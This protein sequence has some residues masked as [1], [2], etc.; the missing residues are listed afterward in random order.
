MPSQ[1]HVLTC[2]THSSENA[3]I[4]RDEGQYS[5]KDVRIAWN[6]DAVVVPNSVN[7]LVSFA[8]CEIDH[9]AHW[10]SNKGPASSHP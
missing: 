2:G 4:S 8:D 10:S 1:H 9:S 5:D 3:L 7:G 6:Q